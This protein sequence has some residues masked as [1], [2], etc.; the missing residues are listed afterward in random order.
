MMKIA[1]YL[2]EDA[3]DSDLVSALQLHGVDIVKAWDV[4]MR[5]R[6]DDEQLAFASSLGRVLYSYNLATTCVFIVTG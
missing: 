5:Q 4:G 3:Q 1:L 2:D 6:E